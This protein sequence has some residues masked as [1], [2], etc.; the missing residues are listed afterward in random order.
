MDDFCFS[1]QCTD[2]RTKLSELFS[3]KEPWLVW[4]SNR[5]VWHDFVYQVNVDLL[6]TKNKVEKISPTSNNH[7]KSPQTWV[8]FNHQKKTQ[9]FSW[10]KNIFPTGPSTN[11]SGRKFLRF[12]TSANSSRTKP[13]K[14]SAA[15]L[16]E[17][18]GWWVRLTFLFGIT[19]CDFSMKK[20]IHK[21]LKVT[22][23]SFK[24][25]D[26]MGWLVGRLTFPFLSFWKVRVGP[27][28]EG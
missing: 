18:V 3:S 26:K 14:C 19:L 9:D 2:V 11:N 10:R 21:I 20:G 6:G 8:F 5:S 13:S 23:S 17:L 24:A 25:P 4:T 1:L 7:Y 12:S 15:A 27:I 16:E 28:F 22:V